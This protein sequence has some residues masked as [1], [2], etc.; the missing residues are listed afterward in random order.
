MSFLISLSPPILLP[1]HSSDGAHFLFGILT[2][3]TLIFLTSFMPE[4]HDRRL[5]ETQDKFKKPIIGR[6]KTAR[7]SRQMWDSARQRRARRAV[8]DET[9][10]EV[11]AGSGWKGEWERERVKGYWAVG[12]Y[13]ADQRDAETARKATKSWHEGQQLAIW[14]YMYSIDRIALSKS[15]FEGY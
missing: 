12:D 14:Y 1:S 2:V 8:S 5:E 4:T 7:P 6:V 9:G 3:F 15:T 10:V 13:V 11:E